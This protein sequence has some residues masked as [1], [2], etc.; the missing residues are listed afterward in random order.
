MRG[1]PVETFWLCLGRQERQVD[2][3]GDESSQREH[4]QGHGAMKLYGTFLEKAH[5]S[6]AEQDMEG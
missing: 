2:K 1:T 5:F 3:A 6:K 4:V